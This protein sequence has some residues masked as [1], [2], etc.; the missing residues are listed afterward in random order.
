MWQPVVLERLDSL[1]SRA[2]LRGETMTLADLFD[3]TDD[4]VWGD[5]SRTG[6][7]SIPEVHRALQQHY[8]ALLAHLMLHPDP[9]TPPDAGALARH[10][11]R[12]LEGTLAQALARGGYD[13]ATAANLE[14]IRATVERA[15]SATTTVPAF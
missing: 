9:G 12:V 3:W 4:A 8:A 14:D 10:H 5:L 13:E 1:E 15:L 7:E 11:L 2:P 6:T